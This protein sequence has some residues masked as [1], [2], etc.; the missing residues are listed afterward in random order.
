MNDFGSMG[1]ISSL[2]EA[3]ATVPTLTSKDGAVVVK[4][5]EYTRKALGTVRV[6]ISTVFLEGFLVPTFFATLQ[7]QILL[8][9]MSLKV[10]TPLRYFTSTLY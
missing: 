5:V 1:V 7:I 8:G 2:G 10:N 6:P 9:C 3:H 4:R